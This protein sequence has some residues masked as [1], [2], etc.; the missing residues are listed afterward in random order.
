MTPHALHDPGFWFISLLDSL[1][2]TQACLFCGSNHWS[3]TRGVTS[4][5]LF[6]NQ[7]WNTTSDLLAMLSRST[8]STAEAKLG[9]FGYTAIEPKEPSVLFASSLF[10][11]LLRKP[12]SGCVESVLKGFY[13]LVWRPVCS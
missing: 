7:N 4:E 6:S 3:V 12:S 5:Q 11:R 1:P 9:G 8:L 13:I 2:V 10:Q